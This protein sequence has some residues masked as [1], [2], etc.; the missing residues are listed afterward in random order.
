MKKKLL[1]KLYFFAFPFS[2]SFAVYFEAKEET[3]IKFPTPAKARTTHCH[4]R[5]IYIISRSSSRSA[6]LCKWRDFLWIYFSYVS[7]HSRVRCCSGGL[8]SKSRFQYD[9]NDGTFTG[10]SALKPKTLYR[11]ARSRVAFREIHPCRNSHG[12]KTI[13]HNLSIFFMFLSLPAFVLVWCLKE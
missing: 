4:T 8:R 11:L 5:K 12:H 3:E 1:E 9:D 6:W 10:A 7:N 2:P 13:L